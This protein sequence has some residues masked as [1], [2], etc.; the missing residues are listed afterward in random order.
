MSFFFA[1]SYLRGMLLE[2]FENL[3][4]KYALIP[5]IP[6]CAPWPNTPWLLRFGT[7]ITLVG[8]HPFHKPAVSLV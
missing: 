6:L 7:D 4:N 8:N 2:G 3:V 5:A 1:A